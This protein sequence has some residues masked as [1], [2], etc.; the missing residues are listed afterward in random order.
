M[1]P[2][3][4]LS[5]S[6]ASDF[7][8]CPLLYRLRTIDKLPEPPQRATTLGTVVHAVLE[9]LF[10]LPPAQRTRDAA[11]DLLQPEWKRLVNREPA[12]AELVKDSADAAQFF[13]DARARVGMYFTLE[14][15][16]RLAPAGRELRLD[17][18]LEG[19][20]A[21]RGVVDRM[22]VSPDGAI[23]IIDYKSG[24]TPRAGYGQ[25]AEFQMRFYAMLVERSQGTRPSLMRL[26][27]LRDGGVKELE[28]TDADLAAV[29]AQVRD[30]WADI[31]RRSS[32][33][34][35]PARPSRLCSWCS[36][37]SACPEF[38]GTLPNLDADAAERVTG[39]RPAGAP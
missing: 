12:V 20:P 17:A 29:E 26:L 11:N 24:A 19:G 21:L 23:R 6:R 25:Q 14:N 35:F 38:G 15:P 30:T 32:A 28:P 27:Y 16:E 8:Q 10:D 37:Q 33:G 5:P 34:N 1:L 18:A 36:F 13:D 7:A 22:D 39:V 2:E 9:R 4:G 3:P 31:Q